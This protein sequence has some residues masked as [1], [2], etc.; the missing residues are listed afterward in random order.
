[1]QLGHGHRRVAPLNPWF[2]F[3]EPCRPSQTSGGGRQR[4]RGEGGRQRHGYVDCEGCGAEEHQEEQEGAE[5]HGGAVVT[6]EER[7]G[8]WGVGHEWGWM[9]RKWLSIER[10]TRRKKERTIG[11][12]QKRGRTRCTVYIRVLYSSR[13]IFLGLVGLVLMCNCVY[14]ERKGGKVDNEPLSMHHKLRSYKMRGM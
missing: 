12:G 6:V 7:C 11:C 1:M 3:S 10:C 8:L 13:D 4:E 14:I 9:D 2:P 5:W